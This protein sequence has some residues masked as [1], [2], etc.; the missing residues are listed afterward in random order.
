MADVDMHLTWND[1]LAIDLVFLAG[2]IEVSDPATGRCRK[3]NITTPLRTR[4]ML[5]DG[6]HVL[7]RLSEKAVLLCQRVAAA[8]LPK[9]GNDA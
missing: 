1:E 4:V 2:H 8:T 9:E 6:T 3:V 5:K 7:A